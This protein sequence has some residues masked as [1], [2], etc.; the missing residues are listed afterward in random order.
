MNEDLDDIVLYEVEEEKVERHIPCI[1][2]EWSSSTDS[3]VTVDLPTFSAQETLDVI[4]CDVEDIIKDILR[5]KLYKELDIWLEDKEK[6][7]GSGI[8]RVKGFYSITT[9]VEPDTARLRKTIRGYIIP[10]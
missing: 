4:S 5:N 2:K 3:I 10:Y 7:L 8:K 9:N 1:P 6:E